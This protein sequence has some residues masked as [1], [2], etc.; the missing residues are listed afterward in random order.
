MEEYQLNTEKG[1]TADIIKFDTIKINQNEFN[2]DL[3]IKAQENTIYFNIKDKN[4]LPSINYKRSMSFKEIKGLNVQF[5]ALNNFSDFYDYLNSLSNNNKLNIKKS[6]DKISIIFSVEV[7]LKQHSIE[8]DLFPEKLDLELNAKEIWEELINIKEKIKEIENLKNE[9]LEFKKEIDYLKNENKEK[10]NEINA[11]KNDIKELNNELNNLKNGYKGLI[12]ESGEISNEINNIKNK[13]SDNSLIMKES[14]KSFIF[15]EIEKKINKKIKKIKMLYRATMDGGD[16]INF[17]NKCDNIPNTLTLVHSKYRRFGGFTPIPW[18][19]IG[20]YKYDPEMK[21]FVFSLDNKKIYYLKDKGNQAVYH[22]KECGPCFGAG[23]DIGIV[24]NPIKEKKLYTFQYSYD[25]KGDNQSLSE[26]V[27]PG[28]L[29]ALDY[30]V[31]Q[32]IFY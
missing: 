3:D 21:T 20:D 19:T 29:Q 2:Y 26:Y 16:T 30:E 23:F 28:K 15:D 9:N 13:N 4:Q 24:G 7:L 17:H 32:I 6:N 5:Q 12:K 27:E 1:E 11:L 25:Y 22:H 31:F 18:S 8:I 10:D 14:E